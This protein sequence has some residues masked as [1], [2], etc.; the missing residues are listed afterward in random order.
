[1]WWFEEY[2]KAYYNR[3]ATQT[4]F[5]GAR[6]F[7]AL[8]IALSNF[9]AED[10]SKLRDYPEDPPDF[11]AFINAKQPNRTKQERDEELSMKYQYSVNQ[12]F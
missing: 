4:Y 12:W 7:D 11:I 2:Q 8:T 9:M 5:T 3:I 1:M 10:N 6:V